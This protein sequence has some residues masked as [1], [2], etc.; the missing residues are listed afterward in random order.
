M[1]LGE[2]SC[3]GC[4]SLLSPRTTENLVRGGDK[5]LHYSCYPAKRVFA[6]PAFPSWRGL[7][8]SVPGR[9][10]ERFHY[11]ERRC[12]VCPELT[13][14]PALAAE[15]QRGGHSTFLAGVSCSPLEEAPRGS[16]SLCHDLQHP[17][18]LL[19]PLHFSFQ[20]P[21]QTAGLGSCGG[22]CCGGG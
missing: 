17:A 20:A 4:W 3:T 10:L 21:E 12:N 1:G 18:W 9:S 16:V 22:W 13:L 2:M 7:G 19:R 8:V 11:P 14:H 6:I 15:G 5:G